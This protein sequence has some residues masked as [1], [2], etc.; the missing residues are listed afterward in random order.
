MPI[1][2]TVFEIGEIPEEFHAK[3]GDTHYRG[4][5]SYYP[6]DGYFKPL[7]EVVNIDNCLALKWHK[8]FYYE[9]GDDPL[10]DWFMSKGI[11]LCEEVKI[12][13]S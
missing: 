3:I 8:G 2:C 12:D 4:L 7:E 13:I 1:K 9:K 10:G 11:K 6:G 5:Q